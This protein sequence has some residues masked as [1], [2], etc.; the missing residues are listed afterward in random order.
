MK[1]P[2]YQ[3][4]P[5]TADKF[6][7]YNVQFA[8]TSVEGATR[9]HIAAFPVVVKKGRDLPDR[10]VCALSGTF[11]TQQEAID[12]WGNGFVVIALDDVRPPHLARA[13]VKYLLK[14]KLAAE[15]KV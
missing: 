9:L 13:I 12:A 1:I 14:K 3:D 7:A 11:E 6:G 8:A 15:V 2:W 10:P 4:V 5:V